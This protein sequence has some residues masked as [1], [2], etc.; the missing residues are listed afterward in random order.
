MQ[1]KKRHLNNDDRRFIEVSL[2]GGVSFAFMAK[3]LGVHDTT[4]TREIKRNMVEERSP[5]IGSSA[6]ENSWRCEA[7]ALCGQ[8]CGSPCK[9]C[10]EI[11]CT[12]VCGAFAR[13]TCPRTLRK[14]YVCNGCAAVQYGADCGFA[15]RFY[16]AEIAQRMSDE[17]LCT[18]RAGIGLTGE[19]LEAMVDVVRPLLR[20]GQSLEHIWATHPG[21]FPVTARTFYKYIEDGLLDIC[22]IELPKK[23]R[24]KKRRCKRSEPSLNPLY[25]GRRYSDFD[26]LAEAEKAKAVEMDCVESARGSSKVLLTLLFRSCNFQGAM[27]MPEHTRA[28]VQD[29]LDSVER[30]IGLEAFREHLGVIVTDHG[31]ESNNFNALEASCTAKGEKRCSIYYCDPNRPDQKGACERNHVLVR[32]VI[33]KKTSFEPLDDDAVALMCSHVNSYARPILGNRAPIEVAAEELPASLLRCFGAE[34]IEPESIVLKPSLL[35]R[36]YGA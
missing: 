31:H 12:L 20:K 25:D 4:I 27:L 26:A 22:N 9:D 32:L 33:P 15:R 2:R 23:V 14:P 35:S 34:R 28:C 29:R 19:E 18:S 6:C 16:D 24:Y 7:R 36:W 13:R 30:E 1:G 3:K 21:E 10:A 8:D 17:R 11:D 5:K